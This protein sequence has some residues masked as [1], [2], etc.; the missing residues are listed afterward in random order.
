MFLA[1]LI[2]SELALSVQIGFWMHLSDFACP[3]RNPLYAT[4]FLLGIL[5]LFC[6][7]LNIVFIAIFLSDYVM[8][9]CCCC[10]NDSVDFSLYAIIINKNTLRMIQRIIFSHFIFKD[11]QLKAIN[12]FSSDF[13]FCC[14]SNW[15]F[16]LFFLRLDLSILW[17][18]QKVF[19][20]ASL[21]ASNSPGSFSFVF[22]EY[23]CQMTEY[24]FRKNN[25]SENCCDEIINRNSSPLSKLKP[26][27]KEEARLVAFFFSNQ[28]HIVLLF[29][30]FP[31]RYKQ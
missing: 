2:H 15:S 22:I 19:K 16:N 26:Q 5:I 31:I 10:F 17:I 27:W 8:E 9:I 13:S 11:E 28:C 7:H 1:S 21:K 29:D 14:Q 25:N 23:I 4:C 30:C 6:F 20:S 18:D 24:S 3:K 12:Y